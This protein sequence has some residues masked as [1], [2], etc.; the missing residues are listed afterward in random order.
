MDTGGRY[1]AAGAQVNGRFGQYTATLDARRM[2]L[3][4]KVFF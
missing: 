3:A 1:D 4:V 2:V